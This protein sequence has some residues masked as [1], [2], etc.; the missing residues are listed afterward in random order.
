M[1]APC[2]A[3]R[4]AARRGA[5]GGVRRAP[6]VSEL[7]CKAS[8]TCGAGEGGRADLPLVATST[9]ASPSTAATSSAT[10]AR[11]RRAAPSPQSCSPG[12]N[13]ETN[14]AP[15]ASA[16]ATTSATW[17]GSGARESQPP[18]LS[19]AR[20]AA[21]GASGPAA[22]PCAIRLGS[23][24]AP[25]RLGLPCGGPR[26]RSLSLPRWK[27]PGPACP[28]TAAAPPT[29]SRRA[30]AHRRRRAPPPTPGTQAQRR[31]RR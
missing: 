25:A 3:R 28:S 8:G 12:S 26:G 7:F 1:R 27:T 4:G 31:A 22:A 5:A 14:C 21:R 17:L 11:K 20:A 18:A 30:R 19:R 9:Q 15:A 13:T 2:S 16:H 24:L 23:I 10:C 29:W 6:A